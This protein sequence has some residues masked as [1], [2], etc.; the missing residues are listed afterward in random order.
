MNRVGPCKIL[1][2]L[3]AVISVSGCGTYVPDLQEF[4]GTPEDATIKVNKIAGQVVC[5]LHRA[6]QRVFKDNETN[7]PT[8]VAAP[9]HPPPKPHNLDWFYKWS[10]QVNLKLNVAED[11]DLTPGVSLNTV[12]P[13]AVTGFP[14]KPAVT[15]PQSYLT[16]FGATLTTTGTRTDQLNMFFSVAELKNGQSAIA[17]SCIPPPT[18]AD[19]FVQSDLKLYDWLS[20]ALLPNYADIIDYASNSSPQNTIIHDVK[21]EIVSDGSVNPSWKLVHISGNTSP[22]LL[23]LGR[24]RTQELIITFG[25]AQKGALA[26]SAQNSLNAI[27]TSSGISQALRN[28]R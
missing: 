4:W 18:N 12:L 7:Y 20:A 5:E 16:G 19:L 2:T 11:T 10:V 17:M 1:A 25:P 14:G 23:S 28:V 15:N 9:G 21:F 24:D 3:L 22:N 27:E 6:V 26:P 8:F 13:S